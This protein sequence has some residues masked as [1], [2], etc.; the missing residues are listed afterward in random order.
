MHTH[1]PRIRKQ[2]FPFR[3]PKVIISQRDMEPFSIDCPELQW[4]FIVPKKGERALYAD[5]TAATWK[6]SEVHEMEGDRGDSGVSSHLTNSRWKKNC[7]TLSSTK[8]LISTG[9]RC[10][11]S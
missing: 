10:H 3:R 7:C 5:Y 1:K 11:E 2:P 6:L 9:D 8:T 4:W